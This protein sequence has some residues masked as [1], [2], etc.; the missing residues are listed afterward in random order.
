[1]AISVS[2]TTRLL[3]IGDSITDCGR[4]TDAEGLGSGYVR[5]IRDY[6]AA[7]DAATVPVIINRGIGGNRIT[8]LRDRWA[9]DVIDEKP[10]VL[11]IKVG[12]NDVWHGLA[13]RTEGTTLEEFVKVYHAILRQVKVALPNC[14]II[15]CEPSVIWPPAPE[16]GNARL[17]PYVRATNEVGREF[18][19]SAVVPLHN[20]FAKAKQT[21]P[22]IVWAGDGVHPSSAGHA[23]IAR[24]WLIST[25]LL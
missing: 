3:F 6:L 5:T 17:K 4:R 9:A 21:R 7:K 2:A 11:S 13:G 25:G 14:K 16:E 20:A 12:I 24:T 19:A 22:D 15:L 8:H 10:D 1:M 18:G 23:L